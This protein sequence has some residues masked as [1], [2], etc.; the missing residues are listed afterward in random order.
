MFQSPLKKVAEKLKPVDSKLSVS[1]LRFERSS[2][3]KKFIRFIKDETEQLE[4]IKL[5]S[6][7]EVEPKSK[8]PSALGLFGLGFITLLTSAFGGGDGKKNFAIGG[9]TKSQF[10]P[11]ELPLVGGLRN[12]QETPRPR[13]IRSPFRRDIRKRFGEKTKVRL[14]KNL[15]SDV[16]KQTRFQRKQRQVIKIQQKELDASI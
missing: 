4:K 3:F 8:A 15:V 5:P 2:D 16:K 13:S 11:P 9:G 7:T 10:K 12:L 6:V 1:S 14:R